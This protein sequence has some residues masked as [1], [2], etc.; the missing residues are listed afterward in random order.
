MKHKSRKKMRKLIG[1]GGVD[2][3]VE[4]VVEDER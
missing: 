1:N 4:K 3:E 2:E